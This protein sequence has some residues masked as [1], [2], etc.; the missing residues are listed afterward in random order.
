MDKNLAEQTFLDALFFKKKISI[1]VPKISDDFFSHLFT[2]WNLIYNKYSPFHDE[3]PLFHNNKFLQDN[4]FYSVRTFAHI[5]QHYFSKYWGHGC[6]GRPP[7]LNFGG[8]P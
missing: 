8:S 3:K 7:T 1:S 6:M 5:Q 2:V 4:F